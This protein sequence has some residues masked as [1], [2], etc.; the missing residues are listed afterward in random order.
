MSKA[1]FTKTTKE[2]LCNYDSAREKTPNLWSLLTDI[3]VAALVCKEPETTVSLNCSTQS[4]WFHLLIKAHR[5]KE[6]NKEI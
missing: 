6:R 2:I 5:E 4:G 3:T 1:F